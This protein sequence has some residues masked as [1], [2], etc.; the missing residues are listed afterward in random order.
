MT[1]FRR[2]I[3]LVNLAKHEAIIRETDLLKLLSLP[4]FYPAVNCF[5]KGAIVV[6][7]FKPLREPVAQGKLLLGHVTQLVL[8]RLLVKV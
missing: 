1:F 4:C 2:V 8:F 3:C 7:I 5:A 6:P